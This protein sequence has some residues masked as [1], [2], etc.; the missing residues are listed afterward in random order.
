V[1]KSRTHGSMGR[2]PETGSR[3]RLHGHEAGNGGHGQVSAYGAGPT[4]IGL[5]GGTA[6][7]ASAGSA[8][9][10]GSAPSKRANLQVIRAS[11]DHMEHPLEDNRWREGEGLRRAANGVRQ[12]RPGRNGS[13]CGGELSQEGWR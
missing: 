3:Q 11:S 4:T 10:R 9:H 7:I 1:R 5:F 2:G 6:A 8:E 12:R 13:V